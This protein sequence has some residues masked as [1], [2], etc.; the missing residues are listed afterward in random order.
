M[1]IEPPNAFRRFLLHRDPS[2]GAL[3][4]NDWA[5]VGSIFTKED[6]DSGACEGIKKKSPLWDMITSFQ[7]IA[8]ETQADIN[9]VE[10]NGVRTLCHL[11]PHG[12]SMRGSCSKGEY[13]MGMTS[14]ELFE[15][16]NGQQVI[17]DVIKLL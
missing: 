9:L 14:T 12:S 15:L 6:C 5:Q 4:I 7:A 10:V 2:S 8:I 1:K 16:P 13:R 17:A 11:H 3:K